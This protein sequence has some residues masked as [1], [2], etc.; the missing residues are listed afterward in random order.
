MI[1]LDVGEISMRQPRDSRTL[2]RPAAVRVATA[3][4]PTVVPTSRLKHLICLRMD[5][6]ILLTG[7]RRN[8]V[9]LY[10]LPGTSA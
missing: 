5:I 2:G 4:N 9:Y 3:E 8:V 1:M 6:I 7:R 10:P